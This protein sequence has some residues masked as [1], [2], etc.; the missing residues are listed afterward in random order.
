MIISP[1]ANATNTTHHFRVCMIPQSIDLAEM[2]D[3]CACEPLSCREAARCLFFY[4]AHIPT[5]IFL[6]Y[7]YTLNVEIIDTIIKVCCN[8]QT[9]IIYFNK[10]K[11]IASGYKDSINFLTALWF[12]IGYHLNKFSWRHLFYLTIVHTY[13]KNFKI[14]ITII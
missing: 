4:F 2:Q 13:K 8:S 10:I 9:L 5:I 6:H 14:I 12:V 1:T 11:S 3:R 7:C